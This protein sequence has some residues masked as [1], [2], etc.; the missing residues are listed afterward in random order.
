MRG[1]AGEVFSIYDFRFAIAD[2]GK[3]RDYVA[4]P[5]TAKQEVTPPLRSGGKRIGL[6]YECVL[7]MSYLREAGLAEHDG[8]NVEA[9]GSVVDVVGC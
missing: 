3:E 4:V 9:E 7:V 6:W 1:G 5:A 2:C 8:N